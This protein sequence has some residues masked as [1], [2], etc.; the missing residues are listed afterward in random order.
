MNAGTPPRGQLSKHVLCSLFE[1]SIP[2]IFQDSHIRWPLSIKAVEVQVFHSPGLGPSQDMVGGRP[3]VAG[4]S[5]PFIHVFDE[6]TNAL[7]IGRKRR[8]ANMGVLAVSILISSLYRRQKH[9]GLGNF[10]LS[11]GFDV[12]FFRLPSAGREYG[13]MNPR[14]EEIRMTVAPFDDLGCVAY[15]A[16]SSGEPGMLFFDRIN[17]KNT[18][19]GF[20]PMDA[21]NPCGEQPLLPFESCNLGSI[22]LSVFEKRWH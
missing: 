3:G 9:G 2:G 5:P 19:P 20:G 13:L 14:K 22:N 21:T 7:E 4:G 17:E 1:D 18:V 11:V 6:V 12:N 16:W 8:G 10:N 15:A